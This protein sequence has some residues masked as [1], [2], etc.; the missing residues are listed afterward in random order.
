MLHSQ[1][2]AACIQCA[3]GSLIK[4][5]QVHVSVT[6]TKFGFVLCSEA[7][8]CYF[9]YVLSISLLPL[10]ADVQFVKQR[11]SKADCSPLFEMETNICSGEKLKLKV[12]LCAFLGKRHLKSVD[13]FTSMHSVH[14][15]VHV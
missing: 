4:F 8:C 5:T 1:C 6:P 14:P 2:P 7:F 9:H 10:H 3:H 13:S 12:N 11:K 15:P